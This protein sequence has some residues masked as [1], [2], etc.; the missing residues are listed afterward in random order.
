MNKLTLGIVAALFSASANASWSIMDLGESVFATSINDS[1]QITGSVNVNTEFERAFITDSNGLNIREI[2]SIGSV[3]LGNEI[4]NSG[5]IL[6]VYFNGNS[7]SNFITQ[8]NGNGM[9]DLPIENANTFEGINDKG[10]LIVGFIGNNDSQYNNNIIDIV[11][12]PGLDTFARSLN[13]SG[14]VVGYY[15]N[16][17]GR[18]HAFITGSDG[19]GIKDIGTFEDKFYKNSIAIDVNES[20][21]TAGV[22]IREFGFGSQAFITGDDGV[23]IIRLGTLGGNYSEAIAIN[24]HG[25]AV[26]VS[27]NFNGSGVSSFIYANGGLTDLLG[28]DVFIG[29]GWSD[30]IV[31]DINNNGQIVGHGNLNNE[32]HSFLLSFTSDTVFTPQDFYIP[33]VP[34]P[35]TYLMLLAGLGMLGFMA[36]KKQS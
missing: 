32:Q 20:G 28:L 15:V 13:N 35:S 9:V 24:D 25:Q 31:T 11:P 5:Q 19:K 6:G 21:Q 16:E 14:Q 3:S 22:L 18:R 33:P 1:G 7:W 4:N 27:G 34:E 2:N 26:G 12:L 23:G 30:I 29:S 17:E 10:Q 36:R 8:Q